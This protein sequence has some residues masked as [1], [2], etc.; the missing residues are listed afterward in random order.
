MTQ[1]TEVGGGGSAGMSPAVDRLRRLAA[2]FVPVL[3]FA[4]GVAIFAGLSGWIGPQEILVHLYPLGWTLGL[5]FLPYLLV[6]FLDALGWR[7]SFERPIS[8]GWLRLTG[9]QIVGK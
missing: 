6:F 5:V 9:L 8:L 2:G 3:P 4:A 1:R 7:Y